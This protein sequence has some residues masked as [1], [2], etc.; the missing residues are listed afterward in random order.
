MNKYKILILSFVLALSG[1]NIINMGKAIKNQQITLK[2]NRVSFDIDENR[3]IIYDNVNFILDIGAPNILF[4]TRVNNFAVIDSI[5]IGKMHKSNGKSIKNKMVILDSINTVLFEGEK[6]VFRV[7]NKDKNCLGINGLLG[8]E[9]F[10]NSIVELN[11]ENNYIQKLDSLNLKQIKTYQELPVSDFDGFYFFID[12]KIDDKIFKLKLDT[13]SPYDILMK[14][15][16]F[17]LIKNNSEIQNYFFGTGNDLDTLLVSK[18][19]ITL[20]DKQEDHEVISNNYLKRNLVGINFMKNYNW[21]LNFKT[22]QVFTRQI[23][24]VNTPFIPDNKVVIENDQLIYYQTNDSNSIVNLGKKILSVN[25]TLI[26]KNNLCYF[27]K[28]LNSTNW[29]NNTILFDEVTIK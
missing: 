17:E 4:N 25:G 10:E 26:E 11:F 12:L 18:H 5:F 23:N 24:D 22:G 9:L 20:R 16:N 2:K 28:Y 1:C 6:M 8:S 3:V 27:K 19:K 15:K 13:G 7:I 21:I 29:K 14:K